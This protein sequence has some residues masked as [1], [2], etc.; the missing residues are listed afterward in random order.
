M[1]IYLY[2]P[3]GN[4]PV[5]EPAL[6]GDSL[7]VGVRFGV[8]PKTV[9][10]IWARRSWTQETRP[11]WAPGELPCPPPERRPRPAGAARGPAR[12]C[13]EAVERPLQSPGTMALL[14]D[15]TSPP[16]VLN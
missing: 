3:G 12:A 4:D 11:L 14:Q 8:S 7:L 10:D 9:R 13:G 5:P 2:R 15:P 16:Q 1:Q 6:R